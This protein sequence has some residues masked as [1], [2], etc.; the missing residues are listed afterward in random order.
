MFPSK[1]TTLISSY[2]ANFTSVVVHFCTLLSTGIR[3]V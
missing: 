1:L 3:T 2:V